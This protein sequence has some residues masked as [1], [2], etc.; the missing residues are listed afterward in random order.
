[1]TA[2]AAHGQSA[3]LM[4]GRGAGR[5][6]VVTNDFPPRRGGIESFVFSLCN[7]L[8]SADVVV[9]TA[10]M[11]GSADLDSSV[12]YPVIRDR[13]RTLLPSRRLAREVRRTAREFGCTRV[14]FGAAAPLGLLAPHLRTAGIGR[15]VALTHGHEV[16][17][18]TTPGSRSL[19]RRIAAEVDVVTYVSEYCRREI[20]RALPVDAAARMR[21]LSPD[22]DL[23]RFG[24]AVPA[25]LEWRGRWQ[26]G[27]RPVVL[28][29][30]RLVARKGHDV[31]LE[32]WPR[33]LASCPRAVL[34][35]VGDGP[36]RR[37][38]QRRISRLAI[39]GSVRL[40]PSVGWDDMPGIYAAASVFA[41][42]CRT[43]RRGREPEA[44]GLVFLEAAA[45]RLPVVAGRSG[46]APETVVDG[47]TG[48]VVNGRDA[49]AVAAA[50]S[51]VLTR[52]EL[53]NAMG[54]RGRA[55]V[56]EHYSGRA[57]HALQTALTDVPTGAA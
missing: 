21:R 50:I 40:M 37:M 27:D 30:S 31:L 56:S 9:Y 6:L 43:R 1:M 8:P 26:V 5:I 10:A 52:P 24:A 42:P 17:W 3:P 34:V 14:V 22:V 4:G 23:E 19:L 20:G 46:G 47:V 51:S 2:S 7:G 18:A 41:L 38:L 44:L 11:A 16:W 35:I 28:A 53:A 12:D 57:V 45:S 15:M 32:A 29:A 25:G 39:T 36:R 33:V 48:H 54:M 55:W 13:S 49:V